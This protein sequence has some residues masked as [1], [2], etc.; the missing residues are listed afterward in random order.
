LRVS[1]EESKSE[2]SSE[3][4][5]SRC[6]IGEPIW[7]ILTFYNTDAGNLLIDESETTSTVGTREWRRA[8][9]VRKSPPDRSGWIV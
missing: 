1:N 2:D 9:R 8:G 6:P 7:L 3:Q 5:F 4:G